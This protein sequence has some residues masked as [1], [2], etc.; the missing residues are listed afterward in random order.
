MAVEQARIHTALSL[1]FLLAVP[2]SV[3]G[4]RKGVA[5]TGTPGGSEMGF[6]IPGGEMLH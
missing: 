4:M 6:G 1:C 2:I 3:I 5:V